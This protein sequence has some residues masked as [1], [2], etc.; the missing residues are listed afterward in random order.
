M[1]RGLAWAA[2]VGPGRRMTNWLLLLLLLLLVQLPNRHT[3]LQKTLAPGWRM[4]HWPPHRHTLLQRA[5]A[6]GWRTTLPNQNMVLQ[7]QQRP[8]GAPKKQ[9]RGTP[10]A[11]RGRQRRKAV[12]VLAPERQKN[13]VLQNSSSHGAVSYTHLTLPTIY[14]V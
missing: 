2:A 11:A 7:Q 1:L 10:L 3:L 6:P 14:S 12:H 5:L 9:L 8:W 13:T 4:T